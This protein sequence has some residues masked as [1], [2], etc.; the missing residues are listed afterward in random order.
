[1]NR[2][3]DLD[4]IR[5]KKIKKLKEK[6][7]KENMNEGK[8]IEVTDENFEEVVSKNE[9][10]IIDAW[11]EWC[12]PCKKLEPV[13]E[14][15]AEEYQDEIIFGKLNVDENGGVARKYGI[16][17]IPTLLFFE[18]GELVNRT[19]GALPKQQLQSVIEKVT[20]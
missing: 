11:A 2:D 15:L 19:V 10:V 13:I 14:E 16:M 20:A 18:D 17:S 4:K 7:E 12:N 5:K 6:L 1:M 3:K 8:P 9:M